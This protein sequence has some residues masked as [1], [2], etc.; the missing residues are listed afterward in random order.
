MK[1]GMTVNTGM[2]IN[3]WSLLVSFTTL[4]A[5]VPTPTETDTASGDYSGPFLT[6]ETA[7]GRK[8]KS[9][10][11]HAENAAWVVAVLD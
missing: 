5:T 6:M 8:D 1:H 11:V 9:C 3:C 2:N 7:R 10:H 4:V